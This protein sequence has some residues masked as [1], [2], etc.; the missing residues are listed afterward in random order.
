[1][2]NS[3]VFHFNW[4]HTSFI[5]LSGTEKNNNRCQLQPVYFH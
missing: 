1:M 5:M 4:F 3:A 2:K